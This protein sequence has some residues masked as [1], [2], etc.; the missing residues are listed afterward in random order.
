MAKHGQVVDAE[1]AEKIV[2]QY[3]KHRE[4]MRAVIWPYKQFVVAM[5]QPGTIDLSQQPCQRPLAHLIC[6]PD[7]IISLGVSPYLQYGQYGLA[8]D[9][10]QYDYDGAEINTSPT[11][12]IVDTEDS[13]IYY[14]KHWR[15]LYEMD[16]TL[17]QESI[18]TLLD[19]VYSVE[20]IC[21]DPDKHAE[22]INGLRM[23]IQLERY[24]FSP[25]ATIKQRP[26]FKQVMNRNQTLRQWPAIEIVNLRLPK[27]KDNPDSE[28]RELSIRFY[29][30]GH[31]RRQWRPSTKDHKLIW[32]EEHIRGPEDAPLKPKPTKVYKVTR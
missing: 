11:V 29:V 19:L 28:G 18:K 5:Q 13:R 24:G 32:I 21:E 1:T 25:C 23:A 27:K 7:M 4:D 15:K 9:F 12:S 3:R 2:A 22:T 8:F 26:T 6:A 14:Q 20:T 16:S 30:K 17:S 10:V 31:L